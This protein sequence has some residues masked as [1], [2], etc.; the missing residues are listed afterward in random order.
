M[1]VSIIMATYNGEKYIRNQLDSIVPYMEAGDE[2]IISD[3]GSTDNTINIVNEYKSNNS[4][5]TLIDGPHRGVI[6]NFENAILYSTKEIIL[7]ADQD[8]IWLPEKLSTIKLFFVDTQCKLVLHD[9][10]M[11]SDEEINENRMGIQSFKVRK[12]K[13]GVIY[14]WIYSGYYGC[15]MAFTKEIKDIIYPFSKYTNMYDQW[16]GLIAEYMRT[17]AFINKPLIIHRVHGTNMSQD[18]GAFE[19]IRIR[20]Q[21]LLA[22][23]DGVRRIRKISEKI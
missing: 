15:C 13:H 11:A 21:S 19:K 2:L 3:D 9:M 14:N 8:D 17:S 20:V 22:F 6:K 1:N 7:F 12:R 5:I 16:I 18:R 4:Q 23:I 10:Y